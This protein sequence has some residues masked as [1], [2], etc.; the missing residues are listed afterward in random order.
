M[1]NW[2]SVIPPLYNTIIIVYNNTI[3]MMSSVLQPYS[4]LRSGTA[5]F[6]CRFY[7]P[8]LVGYVCELN[9]YLRFKHVVAEAVGI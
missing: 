9:Y 6:C 8:K 7:D 3:V 1:V 4:P 5:L 2:V